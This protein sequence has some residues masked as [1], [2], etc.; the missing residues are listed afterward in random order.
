MSNKR[1]FGIWLII[2]MFLSWALYSLYVGIYTFIEPFRVINLAIQLGWAGFFDTNPITGQP[3]LE[4][5][6][7]I[8][9]ISLLMGILLLAAVYGLLTFKEWGWII[10]AIISLILMIFLIGIILLWIL[11]G[12]ETKSAFFES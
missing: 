2:F 12:E 6:P 5:L 7:I 3:L 9:I 10:T 4:M 1:T 8:G 11:D